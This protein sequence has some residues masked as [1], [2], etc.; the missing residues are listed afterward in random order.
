MV[1][2]GWLESEWLLLQL[3]SHFGIFWG[4]LF[5]LEGAA[6]Y[7]DLPTCQ[8]WVWNKRILLYEAVPMTLKD[9]KH[10]ANHEEESQL[11]THTRLP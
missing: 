5:A 4:G 1:H 9:V 10:T 7:N 2:F 3:K 11:A 8:A 6:K